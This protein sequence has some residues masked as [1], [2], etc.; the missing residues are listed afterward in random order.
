[1]QTPYSVELI[2][3]AVMFEAKEEFAETLSAIL[4]LLLPPS[5]LFCRQS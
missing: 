4:R 2:P 5:W 3:S 1:M